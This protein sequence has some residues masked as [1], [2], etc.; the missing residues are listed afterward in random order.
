VRLCST[1]ILG[2]ALL[3]ACGGGTGPPT[4]PPANLR[5]PANPVE[6]TVGVAIR[7]NTPS[8]EGGP[9]ES[10]SV[11]PSLPAGLGIDTSTGEIA[12]T[13]TTVT[14]PAAYTVTASNPGGTTSVTVTIT[15]VPQPGLPIVSTAPI[16]SVTG[17]TAVGGGEV[18]SDGGATV[19][20]RGACWSTGPDPTRA[21]PCTSDG[22]GTGGFTSQLAG[23]TA[24][25]TYNV[26]AYA[27]NRVGTAY[28]SDRTFRTDP[29]VV[30]DVDGNSYGVVRIG[31]QLWLR[32]NLNVTRY[33]DG[34]PI[35]EVT[36]TGA[37]T[38]VTTGAWC[39]PSLY[40]PPIYGLL[41]NWLAVAD[42]HGICPAGWHVPTDGEWKTLEMQLGM[43][44]AE[45]DAEEWR[46]TVEGGKLKT[47]DVTGPLR[48]N[49]P[50]TGATNESGFSALPGG[51]RS[52][53]GV[54]ASSVIYGRWWTATE[55]GPYTAWFR[56]LTYT[57]A[58]IYRSDLPKNW[59][60]S[61]R[62]VED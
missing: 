55:R 24:G 57:R 50:N 10:Y 21:D 61:V 3:A 17:T 25:T 62:C 58:T 46:G 31:S 5:Y 2:L 49:T 7:P 36:E 44:L 56:S 26:R 18:A 60:F 52:E 43:T 1:S 47:T 42:V 11:S 37:W 15:V 14:A 23:L 6:Y 16:S 30:V 38:R 29:S 51:D 4:E 39:T 54:F 45:A 34:T 48:W 22:A 13:P 32:E 59:G 41:Y 19:T 35:P 28:G 27:T 33:R 53:L 8:S 9:V 20:G 40:Y 12:G